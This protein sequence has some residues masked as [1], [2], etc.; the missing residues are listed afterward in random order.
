MGLYNIPAPIFILGFFIC[1]VF[2]FYQ[3]PR[4]IRNHRHPVLVGG[5]LGFLGL[6]CICMAFHRIVM[7]Y[8]QAY[9]QY[10]SIIQISMSLFGVLGFT[11]LYIGAWKN[12][13]DNPEERKKVKKSLIITLGIILVTALG[14]LII[15]LIPNE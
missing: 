1:G 4:Q 13:S 14:L 12:T 7:E 3:L 8:W 5:W 6:G 15:Y 9:I 11:F 2:L 10:L